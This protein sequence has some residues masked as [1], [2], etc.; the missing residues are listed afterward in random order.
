MSFS[1]K[2]NFRLLSENDFRNFPK[3]PLLS[4]DVFLVLSKSQNLKNGRL[5]FAISKKIGN[6]VIRNYTKRH[7][8]EFFRKSK[9]KT[10]PYDFF[11]IINS[12]KIKNE[13]ITKHSI[14]LDIDK[15][16]KQLEAYYF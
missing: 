8:R 5:G 15:I 16:F 11:F 9:L 14:F 4:S 13:Q 1:F 3:K 6:A 10:L 12:K 7:F 2:R